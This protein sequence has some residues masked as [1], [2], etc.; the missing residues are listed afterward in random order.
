MYS[1]NSKMLFYIH[2]WAKIF[3]VWVVGTDLRLESTLKNSPVGPIG[4]SRDLE[5]G[6]IMELRSFKIREKIQF[7][8]QFWVSGPKP[9]CFI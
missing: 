5:V 2:L 6:E 1:N 9:H 7:Y 3:I 4:F 8:S